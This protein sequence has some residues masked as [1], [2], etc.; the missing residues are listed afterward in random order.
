[1]LLSDKSFIHW[2]N[3]CMAILSAILF[4]RCGS[5]KPF[6]VK[7]S[8]GIVSIN[9]PNYSM[10]IQKKGFKYQFT[11]TDGTVIAPFH[12]VSGL[13]LG[14]KEGK[15][16]A[17]LET[18]LIKSTDDSILLRVNF[19]SDL[20]VNV[21]LFP[22]T[23]RMKMRIEPEEKNAYTL[24]AR[25]G[26]L[27]PAY[28]M[29]DHAA[30]GEGAHNLVLENFVRDPLHINNGIDRMVSNFVIFPQ[31][32]FATVNMEPQSAKIIRI[33]AEE[34]AQG[35]RDVSSIPALYYYVGNPKEIYQA[36]LKSR[37][38]EGYS[39]YK[40]KYEWFGVGWEAFGALA[41]NTNHETVTDNVNQYLDYG[42]PLNWMVV[43]S[44]FWPSGSGE[45]DEH[46]TPYN[47]GT[48]SEEAKKLR[49]TTSFGMWDETY[50]PDPSKFIDH[51]HK[52]G[53]IFTIGLRIGFI[54]GG[55]FTEE[56]IAHHYFIEDEQGEPILYKI[57]FPRSPIYLLNAQN[58]EAVSWYVDLSQKWIEYGV[59]GFKEDLFNWPEELPDDLIDPVNRMMMDQGIYIMGRNNYLGSPADIHRFND[60]NYN[61]IQDRGPI[62]G[63][64]YAFSGFPYVYPDIIGG[65][66]LA[67]GRFGDESPDRLKTYLIRY[68]QYASLNPSMSFGY[69]PWQFGEEANQLCLKTALLH[70]SLQPYIYSYAI[71][72]YYTGFPYPMT[73][74]PLAYPNDVHVYGLADTTRRA[75][76]WLIGESLL[77][78]PLFGDD[79]ASVYARDIYLP[80]GKWMDYDDGKVYNGPTTL[81]DFPIPLDK[82]PL[83]VGGKGIVIEQKNDTLFC[84]I[85]PIKE[86]GRMTFWN[87]DGETKS[88]IEVSINDWEQFTITDKTNGEKIDYKKIRFAYQFPIIPGHHYQIQ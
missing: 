7:E 55:P 59:D 78:A 62:N 21:Q 14:E 76:E 84:R 64:A 19:P 63:L 41:W 80:E 8:A 25:T 57:S 66:G 86:E 53:L 15:P 61:Q 43:G 11:H 38:E 79:Y 37:D 83:F 26:P 46:G 1:M 12:P 70:H 75:Y 44:G 42:Y 58:S 48:G 20:K 54:D 52:K 34:N 36:F 82:T 88:E 17:A 69:G 10:E 71:E 28:G 77:A 9:T 22:N 6:I 18:E 29:G 56:G 87:K 39:V 3:P 30:F 4:L 35:T 67:T 32:G 72:S 23:H 5:E 65:T 40:P 60:F 68:A 13:V 24:I 47:A 50:Y 74:L 33:T 31:N 27:G 51:F 49:A 81:R 85:Y 45:F 2:L 16:R 73:P